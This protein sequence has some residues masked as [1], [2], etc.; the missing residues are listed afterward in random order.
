MSDDGPVDVGKPLADTHPPRNLEEPSSADE[1]LEGR[2]ES[3]DTAERASLL[4]ELFEEVAKRCVGRGIEI[5]VAEPN[6]PCDDIPVLRMLF[7]AGRERRKFNVFSA[8]QAERLLDTS[9]EKCRFISGYEAVWSSELHFIEAG[10]SA[11]P[12]SLAFDRLANALGQQNDDG[13][14]PQRIDLL[15]LSNGIAVSLGKPS[16]EY[17]VL[18]KSSIGAGILRIEGGQYLTHDTAKGALELFANSLLFQVDLNLDLAISLLPEREPGT[19]RRRLGLPASISL[20]EPKFA[21]N[22]EAMSIYWYARTAVRF[23]LLQFLAYYQILELY[24]STYSHAEVQR[25]VRNLVKDPRFDPESGA[26][27]N[28]II[29]LVAG[30]SVKRGFGDEKSQLAVAVKACM[31]DQDLRDFANEDE[32]RRAFLSTKAGSKLSKYR[33][34]LDKADAD[35]T[36]EVAARIYDIRCRVVHSK[37]AG[38]DQGVLLPGSSEAR[39]LRH[40]LDLLEFVARKFIIAGSRSLKIGQ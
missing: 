12:T 13:S 17:S 19:Q 28:R 26:D 22:Q 31:T 11:R 23:P 8:R 4:R 7:S 10:V 2:D 32:D 18:T 35:T 20:S 29:E 34:S 27:I 15:Q 37:E 36:G 14:S 16:K 21:Y 30:G 9:F 25:S 40:D 5:E 6:E 24:F 39:S 1:L 3:N 38:G 33:I